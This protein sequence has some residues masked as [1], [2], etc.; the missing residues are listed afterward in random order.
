MPTSKTVVLLILDGYGAREATPDNA[1]ALAAKPN[2]EALFAEAFGLEDVVIGRA[3]YNSAAEGATAT[4]SYL[5]GKSAALIRV[6]KTPSPRATRTFGYTFRF[7]A[8]ETREIVDNLR[9]VRGG[10]FI[11]TS[12]SDSEFVIGGG[13]TGFLYTTVVS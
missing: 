9:G 6:E 7:G 5:W 4:S 1:I 10:V 12:H 13:D 11:K 3:R 2:L 8:I